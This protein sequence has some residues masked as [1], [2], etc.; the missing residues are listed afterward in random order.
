MTSCLPQPEW[1]IKSK[2][3]YILLLDTGEKIGFEEGKRCSLLN[4]NNKKME[5]TFKSWVDS[6]QGFLIEQVR[7]ESWTFQQRN[8]KIPFLHYYLQMFVSFQS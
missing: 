8:I 4:V 2:A 1:K 3:N 7:I 6:K 5:F